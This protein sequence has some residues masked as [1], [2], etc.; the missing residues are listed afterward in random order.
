VIRSDEM[1][2]FYIPM[3]KLTLIIGSELRDFMNRRF[4]PISLTFVEAV[5]GF[6]IVSFSEKNKL[7]FF[8]CGHNNSVLEVYYHV[9]D[10][11]YYKCEFDRYE[12]NYF[13]P[14]FSLDDVKSGIVEGLCYRGWI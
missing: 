6:M 8:I 13:D 1:I 5:P 2:L 11:P 7:M 10:V 3:D 12:L 9:H 14:N 4:L